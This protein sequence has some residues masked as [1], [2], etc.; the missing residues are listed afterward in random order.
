MGDLLLRI[1]DRPSEGTLFD[2]YIIVLC[3]DLLFVNIL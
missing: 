3:V 1:C 2:L